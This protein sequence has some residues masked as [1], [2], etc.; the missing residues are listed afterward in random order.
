LP[1]ILCTADITPIIATMMLP[2]M[3]CG[4]MPSTIEFYMAV[5]GLHSLVHSILMTNITG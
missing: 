2:A 1:V 4:E 5:S 3:R